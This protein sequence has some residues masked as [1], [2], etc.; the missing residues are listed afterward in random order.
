MF[1]AGGR[2]ATVH[3]TASTA[4]QP[5]KLIP[6]SV[7]LAIS[8]AKDVT[9]ITLRRLSPR[10]VMEHTMADAP[11]ISPT[12][13]AARVMTS[14]SVRLPMTATGSA[15]IPR[16]AT[17]NA[18]RLMPG[19]RDLRLDGR[20]MMSPLVNSECAGTSDGLGASDGSYA[21]PPLEDYRRCPDQGHGPGAA[22]EYAPGRHCSS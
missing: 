20:V 13:P 7:E 14:M 16:S 22:D 21:P 12:R 15:T 9:A 3:A 6:I 5:V 11:P 1:T 8:M 19:S 4:V 17:V 2:L 18:A 10:E